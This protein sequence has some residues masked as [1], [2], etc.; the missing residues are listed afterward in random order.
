MWALHKDATEGVK[1]M[2]L[3]C[4]STCIPTLIFQTAEGYFTF[5]EGCNIK[6]DTGVGNGSKWIKEA[7]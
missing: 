5:F 1:V 6:M 4:E 2:H 7:G 3:M